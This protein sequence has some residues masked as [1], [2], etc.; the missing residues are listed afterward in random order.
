MR[1]SRLLAMSVLLVSS[2]AACSSD[3]GS[4]GGVDAPKQID[5]RTIDAPPAGLSG[6]G[7]KCDPAMMNADCPANAPECV[8][9][10]ASGGTY[11]TPLCVTNATA[12]GAANNQLT[13]IT[14]APNNAACTAAYSGTVGMGVCGVLMAYTPPDM[15]IVVDKS[16]TAVSMGCAV[17]CGAGNACPAGLTADMSLGACLC[18][19]N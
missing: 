2:F 6:L 9:L 1:L 19:P 8:G 7:Q 16:Y 4:G 3:G 18:F 14:P 12:K 10:L 15:T 13:M 17:L 11:C 5:A